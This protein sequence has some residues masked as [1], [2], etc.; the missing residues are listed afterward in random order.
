MFANIRD[1]RRWKHHSEP[2]TNTSNSHSTQ[3]HNSIQLIDYKKGLPP[4]STLQASGVPIFRLNY[5]L[6][7]RADIAGLFS[8]RWCAH[9]SSRSITTA[10]ISGIP[11][12]LSQALDRMLLS[13]MPCVKQH[14]H[15]SLKRTIP[16]RTIVLLTASRNDPVKLGAESSIIPRNAHLSYRKFLSIPSRV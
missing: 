2:P 13:S 16:P 12:S 7:R 11:T 9:T 8:S 3:A 15:S 10:L 4:S 6:L 5:R 1:W 14:L